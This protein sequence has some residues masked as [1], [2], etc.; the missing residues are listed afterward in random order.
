MKQGDN[1]LPNIQGNKSTIKNLVLY[2]PSIGLQTCPF[3]ILILI[4]ET[5]CT[6]SHKKVMALNPEF[7]RVRP[8]WA[9]TSDTALRIGFNGELLK[10][11]THSLRCPNPSNPIYEVGQRRTT[12]DSTL[13]V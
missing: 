6:L 10:L 5:Y 13:L 9:V 2:L 11:N 12:P 4:C 7:K 3:F 1:I 8:F